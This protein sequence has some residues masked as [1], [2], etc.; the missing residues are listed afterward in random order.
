MSSHTAALPL[1]DLRVHVAR[2]VTVRNNGAWL[3]GGT[4]FR[5]LRLTE[6]G[7]AHVRRWATGEGD[8]VGSDLG[9]RALARRL[10]DRGLLLS[11]GYESAGRVGLSV[12][13]DVDVVVP[14]HNR[15][16]QLD[17][18]LVALA[19][20]SANVTVVDDGSADP[21]T[22]AT[23]A[24]R[25]GAGLVRLD[26]NRGPGAARNAGLHATSRPFVAFVDSDVSVTPGALDRLLGHFADPLVAVAAPRVVPASPDLPGWVAGYENDH[27]ALDLGTTAGNVG[28]GR[29]VP[30][31]ISAALVAR[32]AAIGLGF[33]EALKSGEDVDL[34]WRVAAAGWRAVYDP[35]AHVRHE[36][37]VR[38]MSL[39]RKRWTYGR[40]VGPLAQRHPGSLA[41]FRASP[42]TVGALAAALSGYPVAATTL[43]MGRGLRMRQVMHGNSMVA[44]SVLGRDVWFSALGAARATRRAWSPALLL[45]GSRSRAVRRILLLA[46][47]LRLVE[48]DR[49]HPRYLPLAALDDLTAALAL[50][51]SCAQQRSVDPL[52]PRIHTG[53]TPSGRRAP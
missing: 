29:R 18:C 47:L 19:M 36:H 1:D 26:V 53:G 35:S 11:D 34:G 24:R 20:S 49:L 4:P 52:L 7:A 44:M 45:A 28:P 21:H 23:I 46:F 15:S 6:S 27:S 43:C 12:R 5:L 13:C 22:I 51:S 2:D 39:L 38:L 50:W 30:Y 25:N 33:D 14:V 41:P 40:S 32:R 37:R 42:L 3:A 9:A 31:V 16:D 10:L 17:R 48:E 8:A